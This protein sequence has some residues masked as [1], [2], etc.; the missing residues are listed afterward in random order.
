MTIKTGYFEI[1]LP[2]KDWNRVVSIRVRLGIG[3]GLTVTLNLSLTNPNPN[4]TQELATRFQSF[5]GN[6]ILDR[7][8]DKMAADTFGRARNYG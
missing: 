8:Q 6:L 4:L 1:R 5:L 3:L 7:Y 2:R